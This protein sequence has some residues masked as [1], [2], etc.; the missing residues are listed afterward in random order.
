MLL[1]RRKAAPVPA[2]R[3]IELRISTPDGV[4][5]EADSEHLHYYANITGGLGNW[6]TLIAANGVADFSAIPAGVDP[7]SFSVVPLRIE[8][9]SI[10][11][12][13]DSDA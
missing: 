5:V 13:P 1:R 7:M 8:V 2:V 6:Q 10:L 9:R 3:G 12:P 11:L 4:V